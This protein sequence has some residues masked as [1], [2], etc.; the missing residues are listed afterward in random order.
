MFAVWMLPWGGKRSH[1]KLPARKLQL[2]GESPWSGQPGEPRQ[3]CL[4]QVSER[5]DQS[6][7]NYVA[8]LQVIID[9]RNN[10]SCKISDLRP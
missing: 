3:F 5:F 4:S 9:S 7:K 10:I 8:P 2:H 1:K 6:K